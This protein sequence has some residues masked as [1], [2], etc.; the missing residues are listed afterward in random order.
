MID[1]ATYDLERA[2]CD[3]AEA[4]RRAVCTMANGKSRNWLSGEEAAHP[5]YATCDNAMRGRVEQYELARDKPAKLFA[6]V[7]AEKDSTWKITT[8]A[9]DVLSTDL[10]VGRSYR[11]PRR[12]YTSNTLTPIRVKTIWGDWY[13]GKALGAGVYVKLTKCRVK[14]VENEART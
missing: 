9:G 10:A 13:H 5:D 2:I 1:Q 3:K 11:N 8:W 4:Y 12:S 7:H 6:Y 14:N